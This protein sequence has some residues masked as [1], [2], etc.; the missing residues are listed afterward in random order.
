VD[1]PYA[2]W[3]ELEKARAE[4]PRSSA[5]CGQATKCVQGVTWKFTLLVS[6]PPDV[7]I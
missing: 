6:V 4:H 5:R 2:R 1:E 7:V 3:A